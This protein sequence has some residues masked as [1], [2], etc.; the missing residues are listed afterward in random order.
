MK[1]WC[2]EVASPVGHLR[3]LS[4]T[5]C[6]LNCQLSSVSGGIAGFE[7]GIRRACDQWACELDATSAVAKRALIFA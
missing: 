2:A 6:G 5:C 3:L 1:S 7:T 4:A